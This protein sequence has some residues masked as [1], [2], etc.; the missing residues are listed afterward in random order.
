MPA[1]LL[2]PAAIAAAASIY[3]ASKQSSAAKSAANTQ[4]GAEQ[5]VAGMAEG[6]TSDAQSKL[7]AA[8]GGANGDLTSAYSTELANLAPYLQ[9]GGQGLSEL[10]SGLAP[11]GNLSTGFDPSTI[12]I[13]K[14][15]GYQFRLAQG[16]KAV[17]ASAAA[18]GGATGGAA[19]KELNNYAQG[20][21]SQEYNNAYS[22]DFNTFESNQGNLY[23]R[24][25][26]L[27]G[28]G[29]GATNS[30]DTAAQLLGSGLSSNTLG[31][32]QQYGNF[33]MEGAQIAG[34]AL[35]G[36]ANATAAGTIGSANAWGTG[37]SGV[38][39]SAQNLMIL[40]QLMQQKNNSGY[41][42]GNMDTSGG[43]GGLN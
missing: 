37:L 30:A 9:A 8:L 31:T 40:N 20:Q 29:Q 22:R 6:A 39:N 24:L 13:T 33:G 21:A 7:L 10:T 2:I 11:G 27:T 17:Q 3:G 35:T 18:R 15:P 42:P 41:Q 34:N 23:N 5:Q 25:M 14:D 43:G 36:G 12:D 38:A 1:A 28:I 4:A 26:A 16:L 19:M 32:A